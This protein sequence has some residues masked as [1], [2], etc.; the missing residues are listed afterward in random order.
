MAK[1]G[2][3]DWKNLPLE[4]K[5]LILHRRQEEE[6]DTTQGNGTKPHKVG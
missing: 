4:K 1:Y 5:D 2:V 3:C 6:V